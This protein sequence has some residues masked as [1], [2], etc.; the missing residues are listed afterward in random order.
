MKDEFVFLL[1]FKIVVFLYL[2]GKRREINNPCG[3]CAVGTNLRTGFVA[4]RSETCLTY[5]LAFTL[6]SLVVAVRLAPEA[7]PRS[8][9]ASKL[10]WRRK[11]NQA[12]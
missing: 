8:S 6:D 5:W 10:M 4:V 1:T 11:T 9:I 12:I 3:L 2:E 7:L